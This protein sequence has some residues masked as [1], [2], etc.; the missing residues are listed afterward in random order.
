VRSHWDRTGV[1]DKAWGALIAIPGGKTRGRLPS[2]QN[3]EVYLQS[4]FRGKA[5]GKKTK[6]DSMGEKCQSQK[7]EDIGGTLRVRLNRRK[8]KPKAFAGHFKQHG[9]GEDFHQRGGV[10]G[11]PTG[12][13]IVAAAQ[14]LLEGGEGEKAQRQPVFDSSQ[15]RI[16]RGGGGGSSKSREFG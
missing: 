6:N 3:Q 5:K 4:A 2:F 8:K 7:G 1:W 13:T 12:T 10:F 15:M 9:G 11:E 16:R 14:P